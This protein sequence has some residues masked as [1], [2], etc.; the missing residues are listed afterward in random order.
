M[1][2]V[3]VADA[4]RD[5]RNL[6]VS[7]LTEQGHCVIEARGGS[8]MLAKS[9]A[10]CP[11]IILLDLMMPLT[12]GFEMLKRLR[13][14]PATEAMPVVALTSLRPVVGES[15]GMRLGVTHYVTKP[16][17]PGEIELAIRVALREA[18][19]V[20]NDIMAKPGVVPGRGAELMAADAIGAPELV[21]TG[22][23]EVDDKLRGGLPLRSLTL[24]E[25]SSGTGKSVLCQHVAHQ[26]L[27]AGYGVAYLTSE[28]SDGGLVDQ[29]A[30]LDLGVSAYVDAERLLLVD[31][32]EDD[33]DNR[34][35]TD[36]V[37][38]R[39]R[40]EKW[41]RLVASAALAAT[42]VP[43]R[44]TT[45]S[46]TRPASWH[47]LTTSTKSSSSASSCSALKR[48]MVRKSGRR[49][50]TTRKPASSSRARAMRLELRRPRQ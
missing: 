3:L 32:P 29:M 13:A 45:P 4:A 6:L 27:I 30:S 28:Y 26:A 31:Q 46:F 10:E 43:S 8:E 20:T 44:A 16:W 35:I 38:P 37:V 22:I 42:F 19:T 5:I 25:G 21:G 33:L 7:T 9:F 12:D 11:D 36:G 18:G 23:R 48:Q 17:F 47:N 49:L 34:F 40:D 24:I 50:A 41:L 2:T 15:L 1:A 14:N 39:M